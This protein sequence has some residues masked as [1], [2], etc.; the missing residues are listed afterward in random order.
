MYLGEIVEYGDT[1]EIFD[2]PQHPYTRALLSSIPTA[3]PR[4]RGGRIE[5]SGDVPNPSNPPVG[6][7]FHTRCPEVIQPEGYEFDQDNW[8]G[9]MDLRVKLQQGQVDPD[10]LAAVV[11]AETDEETDT[12]DDVTDNQLEAALRRDFGL[13][14]RFNDADAGAIVDGAIDEI[15]ADNTG[16]AAATLREEF[17]TV[18]E[19]RHPELV[20]TDAGHPAACHLHDQSATIE[21]EEPPM[22]SDD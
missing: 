2:D 15:L 11:V 19:K 8:R 20:E 4:Q 17:S 9:V 18:C 22:R 6:C 3:D 5:L 14:D 21:P 13:P 1:E 16:K 12:V 10:S 7:R